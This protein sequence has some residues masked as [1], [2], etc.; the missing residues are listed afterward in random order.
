MLNAITSMPMVNMS[1]VPV[2][3]RIRANTPVDKPNI[4]A[5]VATME[6]RSFHNSMCFSLH[7]HASLWALIMF[8]PDYTQ[9]VHDVLADEWVC[10]F[11]FCLVVVVE[12][13]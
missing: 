2:R 4:S 12:S 1:N 7:L 11:V 10:W 9:S 8:L 5:N 3:V 13:C 6:S